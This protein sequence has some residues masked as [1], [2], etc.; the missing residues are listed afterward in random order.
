MPAMAAPP[1][2][3]PLDPRWRLLCALL[4]AGLLAVGFVL[5]FAPPSQE[6]FAPQ[7]KD[8]TGVS[9]VD[10]PSETI[11]VAL[12]GFGV[13]LLLVA[14]NGRK[15]ASLKVGG[16][17]VDFDQ[18]AKAAEKATV[19]RAASGG[20]TLTEAELSTAK[21]LAPQFLYL[22]LKE[23]SALDFDKIADHAITTAQVIQS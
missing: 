5:W 3:E 22:N 10:A 13:V 14:A 4:G 17:E 15:L 12:L 2:P 7:A 9:K 8:G 6:R 11:T 18:L 1:A 19:A 16:N 20:R 21:A 23:G